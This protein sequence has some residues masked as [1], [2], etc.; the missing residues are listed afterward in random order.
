MF[1]LIIPTI[2]YYVTSPE[3]NGC[4]LDYVDELENSDYI[5][6]MYNING[7][8]HLEPSNSR[9]N[10]SLEEYKI[11]QSYGCLM[12]SN[13]LFTDLNNTFYCAVTY[14]I[15]NAPVHE[16]LKEPLGILKSE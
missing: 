11:G 6:Y 9:L 8:P 15:R 3:I 16:S 5:G 7:R 12:A 13:N 1:M 10:K 4:V 2:R 14:M